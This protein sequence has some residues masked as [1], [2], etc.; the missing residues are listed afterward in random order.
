MPSFLYVGDD[1]RTYNEPINRT[2]HIG[3]VVEDDT[4]PD[5]NRFDEVGA[6][7]ALN[8]AEPAATPEPAPE[9]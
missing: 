5:P 6:D 8:P 7:G 2:F 3:D 1:G 9:G 4:N